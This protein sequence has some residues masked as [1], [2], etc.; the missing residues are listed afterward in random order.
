MAAARHFTREGAR[1]LQYS[2]AE[3]SAARHHGRPAARLKSFHRL[4]ARRFHYLHLLASSLAYRERVKE[5][6]RSPERCRLLADGGLLCSPYSHQHH[7]RKLPCSWVWRPM[8]MPGS[9]HAH[10]WLHMVTQ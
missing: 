7:S 9:W 4:S 2:P 8:H 1:K 5:V 10:A 3:A 6:G